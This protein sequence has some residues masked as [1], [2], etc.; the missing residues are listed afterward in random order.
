MIQPRRMDESGLFLLPLVRF[1]A[2][3]RPDPYQV[4]FH[5]HPSRRGEAGEQTHDRTHSNFC[6][7]VCVCVRAC[8]RVC[9]FIYRFICRCMRVCACML[10]TLLPPSPLLVPPTPLLFHPPL[11]SPFPF[12]PRVCV[13]SWASLGEQPHLPGVSCTTTLTSSRKVGGV[14]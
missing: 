10:Q 7:C 5:V 11:F 14:T 9:R 6:V 4:P 8:V 12:R 3:R 1:S 13:C 2:A